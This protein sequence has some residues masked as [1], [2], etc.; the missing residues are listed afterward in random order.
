MSY[1]FRTGPRFARDLPFIAVGIAGGV[2]A[3]FSI[4]MVAAVGQR[5]GGEE[6]TWL[7]MTALVAGTAAVLA[8]AALRG[9]HPTFLRP[10]D[11]GWVLSIVAATFAAL[12]IMSVRGIAWYYL[13]SGL[14]SVVTFMLMT[15]LVVR[16]NLAFFF[17]S[18]TLGTVFGA[19]VMDEIGAFGAAE[20]EVSA[21][22]IAGVMLVA[23]GVVLVRTGK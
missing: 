15:W 9:K 11:Q 4:A 3:A 14:V 5:R 22:R 23:A 16:V 20:R 21:V 8:I 10:M 19:L 7:H 12:A 2:F 1:S 6:A 13:T 17:A 18:N